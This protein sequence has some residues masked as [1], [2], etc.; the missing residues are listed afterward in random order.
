MSGPQVTVVVGGEERHEIVVHETILIKSSKFFAKAMRSEWKDLRSNRNIDL[1]HIDLYTFQIYIHWLYRGTL[2][3]DDKGNALYSTLAKVYVLGEELMDSELK[4]DVLDTI[5]ATTTK[6]NF[7]PG[8]KEITIIYH[9]TASSS[10]ARR[11]MV[12][13]Y[14]ALACNES[15]TNEFESCPKDFLVDA[16]KALVVSRKADGKKPWEVDCRPYHESGEE[17]AA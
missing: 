12:D 9:G 1:A 4:N 10:P 13:F 6:V 15:W 7:Y 8:G 5:I 11:L 2:P 3:I 14:A 17:P 16:M